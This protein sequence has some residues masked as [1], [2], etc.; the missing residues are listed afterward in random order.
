MIDKAVV[1]EYVHAIEIAQAAYYGERYPTLDIPVVYVEYGRRFA[2]IVQ[3]R[4][5]RSVHAFVD[6]TNGD[7][8][9]SAGWSAPQRTRDG[10]LAVRYNLLDPISKANC[11]ASIDPHGGYLY[12]R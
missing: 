3:E 5:Q 6:M 2:R 4:G 7:V 1:N 11:F 12:Q 10:K 8:L 9:K